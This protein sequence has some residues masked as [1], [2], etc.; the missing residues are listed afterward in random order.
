MVADQDIFAELTA[1]KRIL[2]RHVPTIIQETAALFLGLGYYDAHIRRQEN[3]QG[4]KWQEMKQSITRHLPEFEVRF[5]QFGSSFWL[6]GPQGLD[7]KALSDR[8]LSKGV[9]ID[10]GSIFYLGEG[11]R[12][13][14]RLGFSSIKLAAID[15]GIKHVAEAA[16]ALLG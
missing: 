12:N 8:L 7:S 5:S 9:I 13:S 10:A 16:K 15:S 3:R 14:F 1:I 11:G 4:Q 6:T 2:L